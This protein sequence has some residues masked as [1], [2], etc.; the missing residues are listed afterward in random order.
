MIIE[1]ITGTS[2]PEFMRTHFFVPLQMHHTF[3]YQ[4]SDTLTAT[5]SFNYNGNFWENDCLDAT[6]GDKNIYSTPRDLLKWDQALYTDQLITPAL[7]DS[8]FTPYSFERPSVHNYGLGFRMLLL[9]NQ[10]KI[11]YHFGRWHGFNAAFSRLIDQQ[12]TIIILGNK[13]TR[14]VYNAAT[15]SYN[16]FGEYFEKEDAEED[17]EDAPAPPPKKS[18][19]VKKSRK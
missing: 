11:V 14:S 7:L 8:A 9:P 5:P 18:S 1:E 17:E 10:K 6:Y 15:Q 16:L 2:F 4:L 13:F 3:V 19:P 12:V